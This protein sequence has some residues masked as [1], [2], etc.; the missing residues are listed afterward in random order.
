MCSKRGSTR[1]K[2]SSI[3]STRRFKNSDR[4]LIDFVERK[5]PIWISDPANSTSDN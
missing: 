4:E 1:Q 3:P 2:L 5:T